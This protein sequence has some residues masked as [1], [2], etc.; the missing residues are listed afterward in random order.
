[1]IIMINVM[2]LFN[3]GPNI[4]VS[5]QGVINGNDDNWLGR[6]GVNNGYN[7]MDI[8]FMNPGMNAVNT[9]INKNS[10]VLTNSPRES[11][12]SL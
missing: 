2:V 5:T 3:V 6:N 1:M 7:H 10:D 4:S 9:D 11:P 12:R 8:S